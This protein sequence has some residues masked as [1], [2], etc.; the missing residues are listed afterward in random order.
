MSQ[1][2]ENKLLESGAGRG[3]IERGWIKG[4]QTDLDGGPSSGV[5][6]THIVTVID[7]NLFYTL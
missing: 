7:N 2:R 5:L 4:I 1:G 3:Q 6:Q